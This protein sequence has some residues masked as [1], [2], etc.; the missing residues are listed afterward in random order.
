M[1]TIEVQRPAT[2]GPTRN[3]A[4]VLAGPGGAGKTTFGAL[5]APRIGVPFLDLDH[6][7]TAR[8]GDISHFLEHH[9]YEA[10][11][12]RNV[13]LFID[14]VAPGRSIGVIALS[15]GF[16]TYSPNVHPSYKGVRR[17]IIESPCTAI[18]LPSFDVEVCV[19]ETVRRQ[20]QR[21]F[22]RSA[23]REEEVI[24]HRFGLYRA[25][26]VPQVETMRNSDDV[27]EDLLALA[28]RASAMAQR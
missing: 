16:M 5:L 19:A 28:N 24:R 21:P 22:G 9:G 23:E 11:A 2:A 12:A 13:Q 18:L 15:S 25:L 17:A 14:T 8:F 6:E 7:F 10:Y 26:A 4:V 3:A 1:A 20:I 27:V